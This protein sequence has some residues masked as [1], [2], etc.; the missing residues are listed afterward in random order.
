MNCVTELCYLITF[1][2]I[3]LKYRL[4]MLGDL[5]KW[6]KY[7]FSKVITFDCSLKKNRIGNDE[8]YL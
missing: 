3:Y 4:N 6:Q 1:V 2:L 5:Y 7:A 8:K